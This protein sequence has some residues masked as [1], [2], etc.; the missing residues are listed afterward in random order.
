MLD[1][2]AN[3]DRR[4]LPQIADRRVSSD[5]TRKYVLQLH[6]G[7][8]VET[9]GIPHGN[10]SDPRRL[11]V[12]FSTQSGCAMGCAF[13]ATGKLGLTRNLEPAEM[14]WQ[15]ALVGSNFGHRAD[16]AIAMGQGEP[17]AN[18]AA[19]VE[20][21][22][23]MNGAQGFG[24]D[25]RDLVVS[26]CGIPNGIRAFAEDGVPATLAVSLHAAR[27]ELRDKLMPG[28]RAFPLARLRSEL[29]RYNEVS[30]KRV[31]IQYLMLD[32]INDQDEDFE[33]IEQFCRGLDAHV[34]LLRFN[35]A[36]GIPFAPSAFGRMLVWS[37]ELN[38]H[39]IPASI[40]K[41]RGADVDA[42]CGQLASQLNQAG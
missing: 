21:L 15:V 39:G 26:T 16:S 24:I 10:A 6:D 34:S 25:E 36:D 5:G 1:S 13:C 11:T 27:Q 41:P 29:A 22:G 42:A 7:A 31:I 28:V 9:V 35:R 3:I 19:L 12:C 23:F 30:G 38:Q 40:N 20:S 33:A 37:A 4:Y 32:G 2:Y 14:V 18:Y 17:L 8:L